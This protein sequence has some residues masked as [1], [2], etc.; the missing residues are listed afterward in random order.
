[1]KANYIRGLNIDEPLARIKSDG[2]VRY[3][4]QDALGSVIAL[5]DSTGAVK[6]TYSYDPFGNVTITGEA[7]DNPFQFAGREND[8]TGHLF[9]RNRYYS[10]E[11]S[12]Y[13]SQDPIGIAGGDVN[14]YVRVGNNPVNWIDPY[15]LELTPAQ[16]EAIRAAAQNWSNSNVPYVYGR[17]TKK[18]ADCSGAV[19]GIYNQAGINIGRLSSQGFKKSPFK[20][21]TGAP[22]IGDVGVYPGHVVLYG[23]NTGPNMDVWSASHTGGPVFGPANSSWYGRPTWYRYNGQ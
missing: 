16:Q 11:L 21:V 23:S 13:I 10:Y 20:P 1:V 6:T 2:T 7:S 19:S 14:Y 12:R 18:G 17:Y 15:G 4:Q 8:N 3:Y 22:Q 5:T 9:E